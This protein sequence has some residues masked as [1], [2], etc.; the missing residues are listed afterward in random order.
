MRISTSQIYDAGALSIQRNQSALFKLQNQI[1]TGRRILTPADDPVAAAQAL[2]VTQSQS[3][4]EQHIANQDT[5][6]SQLGMLDSQLNSLTNLLQSVRERAVQAGNTTLSNSD[7]ESIAFELEARLDEMLGIANSDN[8]AG[9]YLFSGYQ[10]ATKPF[11][12]D[13]TTAATAPALSSP[14]AYYGDDGERLL[15]VSSSRQMAVNVTGSDVFMNIK[16]GNGSFVAA[17]GVDVGGVSG[18]I[19]QGSGIIDSGS[20][21]DQQQWQSAVNDSA[22]GTPL[23]IRFS[24]NATTGKTQYAIYDPVSTTP[25]VLTDY[26]AGQ[27][28]ALVTSDGVD[29]ASQ[30]VITGQPKAG[31]TF[32]V[33][34]SSNQSIF[35]TM[36]NLIGA[37]RS[38]VGTTT[39]TTTQFSNDL[40]S[41]LGNIDQAI[42]NIS[43]V[44]AQ[45][46]ARMNELDSLSSASSDLAVQYASTLSDLQDLDYAKALSDFAKQEI[47]LE[48]AQKSFVQISGLSLFN[49]L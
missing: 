7:R 2:V 12:I 32:T 42:N 48:A 15:Q 23:E 39:Y 1:S 17:T 33:T 16:G 10:G 25:P 36:Q 38:P 28:I 6:N 44:Q 9:D 20:V 4:T 46:G 45:V 26:V 29:F 40:G 5:A 41:Q 34:P 3:V 49:Y 30:V 27:A 11:A 43:S 22:A 13:G 8:G 24:V 21:L 14:Y 19:N 37:L 47:N 18:A 35:Q 31:D